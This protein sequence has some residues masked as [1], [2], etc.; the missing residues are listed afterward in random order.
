MVEHAARLVGD[1]EKLSTHLRSLDDLLKEAD[2]WAAKVPRN[3]ITR[4]DIQ[5][6]IDHQIRRV[7][8]IRSGVYETSG[9]ERFSSI[10]TER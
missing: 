1:S 6:A 10:L 2:H 9:G 8:R 5:A 7:D 3:I 4:D